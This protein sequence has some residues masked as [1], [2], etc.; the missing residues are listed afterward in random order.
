M[1]S[2]RVGVLE[3][4]LGIIEDYQQRLGVDPDIEVAATVGFGEEL[5]PMLHDQEIDLLILDLEVKCSPANSNPFPVLY[6]IPRLLERHPDLKILISS[7]HCRRTLVVAAMG[8]GAKGYLLKD[9]WE[10]LKNLPTIIRL[11]NAGGFYLSKQAYELYQSGAN[12]SI[13]SIR[14]LE[15]LTLCAAY[16]D[17]S[18][19]KLAARMNIADSTMRSLLSSAYGKLDVKSRSAAILAAQTLGLLTPGGKHLLEE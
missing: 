13:L 12:G 3:D 11:V 7:G 19:K 6:T 4:H 17:D 18:T 1:S 2:I 5:E 14:E 10:A 16:P 15:A 9:D 8:A